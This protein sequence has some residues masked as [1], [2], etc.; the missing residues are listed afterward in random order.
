MANT[1]CVCVCAC[2]YFLGC[3]G[4]VFGN[5]VG[6]P[7]GESAK[8]LAR[9]MAGWLTLSCVSHINVKCVCCWLAMLTH[10]L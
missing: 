5:G 9:T 2:V 3:L 10:A 4:V 6:T 7:H 8:E 1:L